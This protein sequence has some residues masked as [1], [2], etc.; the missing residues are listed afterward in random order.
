[1]SIL[2]KKIP[3]AIMYKFVKYFFIAVLG[4]L[5]VFLSSFFIQS[6]FNLGVYFGNFIRGFYQ[7]VC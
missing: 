5:S 1:M 4:Y 7:I 3:Y 6:I 2:E